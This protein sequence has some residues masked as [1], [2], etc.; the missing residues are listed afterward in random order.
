MSTFEQEFI[1]FE[2]DGVAYD[3]LY[4]YSGEDPVP[5]LRRSDSE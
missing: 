5:R 4:T 3:P 1:A 2:R